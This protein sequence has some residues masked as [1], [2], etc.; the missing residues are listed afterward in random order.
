MRQKAQEEG[1]RQIL[2]L[3]SAVLGLSLTFYK[4]VLKNQIGN[5][6][7]LL[8]VAWAGWSVAILSIVIS[9]VPK[10]QGIWTKVQCY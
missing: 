10:C 1:D 5:N 6:G 8:L 7:W 2:T 3:S 4:E 9:I